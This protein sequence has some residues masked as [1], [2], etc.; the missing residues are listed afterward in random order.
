METTPT[1]SLAPE[2]QAVLAKD[3]KGGSSY[4]QLPVIRLCNKDMK[5]TTEGHYFIETRKGKD[6]APEIREIGPN[7]EV[8]ILYRTSTY[9]YFDKSTETL[10][11]WTTDIHGYTDLDRLAMFVNNDGKVSIAFDGAYPAFK[12]FKKKYDQVDPVTEKKKG[13]LLKFKTVLY[14]LFEGK[15]YKMF[16]STASSTGIDK[17]GKADFKNPQPD[18]FSYFA[19]KCWQEEHSTYEFKLELG[20]RYVESSKPYYLMTFNIL[21]TLEPKELEQAIMARVETE[22]AIFA[23]DD[24]RRRSVKVEEP[25]SSFGEDLTPL[26][27]SDVKVEDLPF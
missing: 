21:K 2:L 19:D 11:A 3:R 4:P 13:S 26:L 25:V 7:P 16:V 17:E 15:P 10:R 12:E 1:T 6:E 9:S 27:S 20:S 8:T 23:I 5:Q 24:A 18:S 22:K 14:V